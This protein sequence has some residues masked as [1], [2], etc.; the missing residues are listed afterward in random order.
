MLPVRWLKSYKLYEYQKIRMTTS[1]CF[2]VV[3]GTKNSSACR[4][5]VGGSPFKPAG[6][7]FT[8]FLI[9]KNQTIQVYRLQTKTITYI[10]YSWNEI[11]LIGW[12]H[13]SGCIVLTPEFIFMFLFHYK[14]FCCYYCNSIKQIFTLFQHEC[15]MVVVTM[16]THSHVLHMKS[17]QWNKSQNTQNIKHKNTLSLFILLTYRCGCDRCFLF[18]CQADLVIKTCSWFLR[19]SQWWE[20]RPSQTFIKQNFRYVCLFT[21]YKRRMKIEVCVLFLLFLKSLVL[22]SLNFKIYSK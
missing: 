2:H 12:T 5:R 19:H 14:S 18:I 8:N 16:V 10:S 20:S 9:Y 1:G 15:V 17:N 3:M 7:Q 13:H 21:F 6:H 22:F 4:S 11:E